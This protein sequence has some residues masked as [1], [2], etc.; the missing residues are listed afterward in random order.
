MGNAAGRWWIPAG[1][2]KFLPALLAQ[3]QSKIYGSGS[4]GVQNGD[5]VLDCGAHIGLYT[6][7]ALESGAKLVVAIEPAP[8][9]LECLRRNL[10]REIAD[11]RVIVLPKGVWDKEDMLVLN[12]DPENSA[13]DSFIQKPDKIVAIKRSR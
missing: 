4:A 5:V 6:R 13:A 9:N 3:E 8:A 2:D 7:D 11:G 10:K 12:E 1:S